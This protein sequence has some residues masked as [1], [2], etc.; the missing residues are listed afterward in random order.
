MVSIFRAV[1]EE[2]NGE[3]PC[4]YAVVAV[5]GGDVAIW[6]YRWEFG[7]GRMQQTAGPVRTTV[8]FG[9]KRGASDPLMTPTPHAA[10]RRMGQVGM[11][12]ALRIVDGF[13]LDGR[14]EEVGE[15]ERDEDHRS[16]ERQRHRDAGRIGEESEERR[17]QRACADADG[18]EKAV[19]A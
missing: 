1:Q 6:F 12:E 7:D 8:V 17:R 18:V 10:T 14:S 5:L 15:G 4:G 9:G 13:S 3:V 11:S 16:Q 2:L 19:T